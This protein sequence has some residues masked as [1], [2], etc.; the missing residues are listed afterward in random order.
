MLW[1]GS[2]QGRWL[3]PVIVSL[4]LICAGA[5]ATA[6]RPTTPVA[7]ASSPEDRI[8]IDDT[9]DVRVYGESEKLDNFVSLL[10]PFEIVELVRSGKILMVRGLET[11]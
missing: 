2:G 1:S 4:V 10:K 11:T 6:P 7:E 8:G 9:F 5:C 3:P